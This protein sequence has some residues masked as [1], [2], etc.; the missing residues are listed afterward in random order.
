MICILLI[1]NNL[2]V[3]KE[4]KDNSIG[5]DNSRNKIK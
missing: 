1:I 3:K 2:I 4:N 5:S